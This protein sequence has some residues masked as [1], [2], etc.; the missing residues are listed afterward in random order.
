M[1]RTIEIAPLRKT[2]VV[3]AAQAHA[4]DVFTNGIDRWFP[5]SHSI[6][7]SPLLRS[8]VESRLGGRWYSVH[9]DGSEA[10]I[11]VMKVWEPPHRIVFSWE[12]N[13]QWKADAGVASEVEVTFTAEGPSSTRVA[14]E[15][16]GFEALGA[17]GGAKMRGDVDR[18]WPLILDLFKQAAEA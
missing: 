11:G 2:L 4:F 6:G 13:A 10:V 8:V 3:A 5:R 16:R 1:S 15:H 12:I 17:E 18:G 7:A 9:E 14:L